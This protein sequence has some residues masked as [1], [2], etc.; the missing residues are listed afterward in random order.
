MVWRV[1]DKR[2]LAPEKLSLSVIFVDRP[3]RNAI[4]VAERRN[5]VYDFRSLLARD[6]KGHLIAGIY[7]SVTKAGPGYFT[8][9]YQDNGSK[10][11]E[12]L[13]F[14]CFRNSEVVSI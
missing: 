1:R 13:S 6:T 3:F 5:L 8:M 14:N 9:F 7:F 4:D 2:G 12:K 11:R 10:K